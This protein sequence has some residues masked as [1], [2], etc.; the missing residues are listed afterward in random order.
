MLCNHWS[1]GCVD[2]YMQDQLLIFMALCGGHCQ[3]LT[4]PVTLHSRT[5]IWLIEKMT[6]TR[7]TVTQYSDTTWIIKV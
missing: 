4:G 1:S 6:P 3:I 2:E 7:F 5:A